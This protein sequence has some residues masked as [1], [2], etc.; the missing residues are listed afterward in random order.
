MVGDKVKELLAD[1]VLLLN[2]ERVDNAPNG[3]VLWRVPGEG[4]RSYN[5]ADLITLALIRVGNTGWDT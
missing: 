1:A 4:N 3:V 5:T 2:A